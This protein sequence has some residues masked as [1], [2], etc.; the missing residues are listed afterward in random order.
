MLGVGGVP[1][2]P[3]WPAAREL[4]IAWG[5]PGAAVGADSA[6]PS[7]A[8]SGGTCEGADMRVRKKER[9]K[10]RDGGSEMQALLPIE[11]LTIEVLKVPERE[12]EPG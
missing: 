2:A 9:F 6:C 1:G 4:E 10:Y 12:S 8:P 5:V 7:A 3:N 11:I